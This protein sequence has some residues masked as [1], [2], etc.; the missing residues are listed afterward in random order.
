MEI[1]RES[2]EPNVVRAWEPGRVR[3]GA[4][5]VE[6]HVII[7]ADRLI[8]EWDVASAVDI[9]IEALR[10]AIDLR[11][12]IIIVGTGPDVLLPNVE[13][14]R[15]LAAESIGLE[16]MTTPAAIRTFNVLLNEHRRVVVALFNPR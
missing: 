9:G 5:W 10:P 8:T 4:T 12:E 16:T 11:P 14:M 15:S 7:A 1:A 2:A 13:L 3:V 6:G